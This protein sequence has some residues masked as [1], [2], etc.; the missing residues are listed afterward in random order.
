MT[1]T[2]EREASIVNRPDGIDRI[3][4]V[5]GIRDFHHEGI[6][7]RG[8]ARLVAEDLQWDLTMFIENAPPVGSMAG[9]GQRRWG[10]RMRPLKE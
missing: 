1:R 9:V 5:A 4:D 7:A 3:D 6:V 8:L 2:A 10:T